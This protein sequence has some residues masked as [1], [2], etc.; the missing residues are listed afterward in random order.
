MR[1][2]GFV[3]T[4]ILAA[5]YAGCSV[6]SAEPGGAQQPAPNA[7]SASGTTET[8]D[9]TPD[10]KRAFNAPNA[11]LIFVTDA[12][13][14]S[15]EFVPLN[16]FIQKALEDQYPKK[17]RGIKEVMP[18]TFL[19]FLQDNNSCFDMYDIGLGSISGSEWMRSC[20]QFFSVNGV[21]SES[22]ER[23]EATQDRTALT[24]AIRKAIN[25]DGAIVADV[26]EI[27]NG[28]GSVQRLLGIPP[29]YHYWLRIP[30]E[31]T[32][33]IPLLPVDATELRDFGTYT[34][35]VYEASVCTE[36]PTSEGGRCQY[37]YGPPLVKQ[38]R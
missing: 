14:K 28:T 21:N 10:I 38:C 5:F 12:Q 33:R 23:Y 20:T 6:Q 19:S 8:R 31:Q 1:R 27:V 11:F 25:V 22:S 37:C 2:A 17:I 18:F 16:E 30:P 9:L 35:F 4:A 3:V 36:V 7:S 15:Y 26:Y 34:A 29:G 13:G 32:V 24:S